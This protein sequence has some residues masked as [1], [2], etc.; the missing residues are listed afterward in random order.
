MCIFICFLYFK[1]YIIY[2]EIKTDQY[3]KTFFFFFAILPSPITVTE[4]Q[5]VL[6]FQ[7]NKL[8]IMN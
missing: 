1:K 4:N 5:A 8:E 6:L 7:I 2:W 3:N